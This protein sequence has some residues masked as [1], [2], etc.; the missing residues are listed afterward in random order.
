MN[1]AMIDWAG[2]FAVLLVWL[3]ASSCTSSS[4]SPEPAASN[5]SPEPTGEA[6]AR[7]YCAS[8]HAFP[9]PELLDRPRWNTVLPFMGG[10]L[11]V[12]PTHSRDS[13]ISLTAGAGIDADSL[14][15]TTPALALEEWDA[16][17]GYYRREA[18]EV[19]EAPPRPP[20]T[21]GLPGF[22][23]RRTGNRFR[24]PL[25]TLAEIEDAGCGWM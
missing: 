18:P 7:V 21:V 20:I 5:P 17:V 16:I 19:L 11:G 8:C 4:S 23:V 13:L 14:Y 12:Y 3:F 22:Q 24:P 2:R 6:L 1:A 10:R 15:P 9:E 25:T